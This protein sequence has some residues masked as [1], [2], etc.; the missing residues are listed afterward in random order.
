MSSGRFLN[1]DNFKLP[2]TSFL[3][4]NL[5]GI[6][7]ICGAPMKDATNKVLGLL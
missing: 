1:P 2:Q 6:K 3:F 4:S 5:A 7:L